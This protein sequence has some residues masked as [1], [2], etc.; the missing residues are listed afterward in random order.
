M[1]NRYKS[2]LFLTT[3]ILSLQH[4]DDE[5]VEFQVIEPVVSKDSDY[6]NITHLSDTLETFTSL[7][8][9]KDNP[10]FILNK[11]CFIIF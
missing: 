10:V 3:Q 2:E 1:K 4:G 6:S 5:E 11:Y 9:Q 8:L 7:T